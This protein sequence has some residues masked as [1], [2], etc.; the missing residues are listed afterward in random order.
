MTGENLDKILEKKGVNK[1]ALADFMRVSRQNLNRKLK[2]KDLGLE[3]LKQVAEFLKMPLESFLQSEKKPEKTD[4]PVLVMEEPEPYGE[5]PAISKPL[6]AE[7]LEV[8]RENRHLHNLI[9]EKDNTITDL[10]KQ[11]QT[12]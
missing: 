3:V 7:L 12:A 6:H 9:H 8:Y 5:K 1:S 4:F 11:K 10:L 2:A